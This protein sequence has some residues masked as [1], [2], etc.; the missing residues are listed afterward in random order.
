[1]NTLNK[2]NFKNNN[3]KMQSRPD[4]AIVMDGIGITPDTVVEFDT[5]AYLNEERDT[6][7]EAAIDYLTK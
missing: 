4:F 7:L 6:Q 5:D 1:M 3:E 2:L